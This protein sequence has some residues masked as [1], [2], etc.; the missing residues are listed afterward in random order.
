MIEIGDFLFHA[1]AGCGGRSLCVTKKGS[2]AIVPPGTEA[3]DG[4]CVIWGTQMPFVI[5]GQSAD[6]TSDTPNLLWKLVGNCYVHGAM[7]GEMADANGHWF[8][9]V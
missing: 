3:G 8:T 5:R 9:L 7:K 4:I 6:A 2:L 1:G